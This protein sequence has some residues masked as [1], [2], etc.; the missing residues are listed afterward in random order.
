MSENS[1]IRSSANSREGRSRKRSSR[2][3]VSE[4]DI[5]VLDEPTTDMDIAAERSIMQLI[6]RLHSE[7]LTVVLVS[8]LLR[9]VVNYVRDVAFVRDGSVS[10]MSV[11]EAAS[12]DALSRLY[13]CT[14]KVVSIHGRLVV[15]TEE[16]DV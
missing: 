9:T 2:A 12:G 14:V 1:S 6:R 15:T 16:D 11:E 10:V 13:G 7:G 5:L 3:L 8:H 4:P